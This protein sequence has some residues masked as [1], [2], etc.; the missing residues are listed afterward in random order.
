M[1][2]SLGP[3]SFKPPHYVGTETLKWIEENTG[4][5]LQGVDTGRESLNRIPA[6]HRV[7]PRVDRR[8]SIRL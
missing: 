2:L 6:A 1:T 3:F 4:K 8:W 5:I 7:S